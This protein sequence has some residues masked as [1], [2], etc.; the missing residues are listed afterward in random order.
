MMNAPINDAI[1]I[2]KLTMKN[3]AINTKVSIIICNFPALIIPLSCRYS[4]KTLILV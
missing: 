1:N 3:D 4:A 2:S